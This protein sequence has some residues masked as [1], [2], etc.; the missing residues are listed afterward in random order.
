VVD[1]PELSIPHPA[2]HQRRFVL[3]PLVEIA[4]EAWHPMMKK[5]AREMLGDL[6]LGQAVRRIVSKPTSNR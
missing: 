6:P 1:T 3:E 2:M 4:P 5:N